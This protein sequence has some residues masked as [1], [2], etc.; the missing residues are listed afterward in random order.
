MTLLRDQSFSISQTRLAQ[1]PMKAGCCGGLAAGVW[2]LRMEANE[3]NAGRIFRSF[4]VSSV[5]TFAAFAS[6]GALMIWPL[7][8]RLRKRRS[9]VRS[10]AMCL[11]IVWK[12]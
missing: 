6:L 5:A 3:R 10:S 4:I 11:G 7:D 12:S 2:A 9:G 8:A 1:G